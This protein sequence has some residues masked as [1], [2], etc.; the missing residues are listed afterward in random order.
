MDPARLE[1]AKSLLDP[2]SSTPRAAIRF[3]AALNMSV[4]QGV[5]GVLITA[6]A[7]EDEIV[8]QSAQMSRKRGKIVLVGVVDLEL[9]RAEWYKKEL[10]F[11][12][13]CSYGPG[14]YDP[15][16]EEQGHDYPLPFV[17]LD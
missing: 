6:S 11:Q 4:G 12:V 8:S 3:A 2:K 7:K 16:Y 10:S 1:L 15:T 9:N 13:S 17:A 5:D 14:R